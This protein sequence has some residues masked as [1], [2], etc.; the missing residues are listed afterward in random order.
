[1]CASASDSASDLEIVT[2][3]AL[4]HDIGKF[5]QRAKAPLATA[6]QNFDRSDY[7]EHGQ[8]A[9]YSAQFIDNEV[10]ARWKACGSPVLF[11]H[12]PKDPLAAIVAAADRFSAAEREAERPEK[13]STLQPLHSIFPSVFAQDGEKPPPAYF[14]LAR[15]NPSDAEAFFPSGS[16][17]GPDL[18]QKDYGRLWARFLQDHR[19]LV[20]PGFDAYLADLYRL[21]QNYTCYIPSAAYGSVPDISLFDHARTAAAIAGALYLYLADQGTLSDFKDPRAVASE[22]CFR[23]AEGDLSGIQTY[24]YDIANVGVGGVARRLRA[25]SLYLQLIVEV[26][27]QQL[28]QASGL[29][30]L[31]ALM[32]SGG[33]FYLLLPN[34]T[35]VREEIERAQD[36][37]DRWLRER[38][39]AELALN[40]ASVPLAG[41]E[42]GA[43]FGDVL[44]RAGAELA[45]RK[46]NRLGHALQ[47]DGRWQED[48]FLLADFGGRD[49]CRSCGQRPS[50]AGQEFCA[51]C[52][53]DLEVG[54]RL[55]TASALALYDDER[56]GLMPILGHSVELLA[57]DMLPERKAYLV[58]AF[59]DASPTPGTSSPT[60]AR[61]LC[62]YLP[63]WTEERRQALPLSEREEAWPGAPVTFE[64]LA[65][66][67]HGRPLL[68]FL[69]AD[70]DH[71]GETF[72][73]GLGKGRDTSSRLAQM[74]RLLDL[75]FSGWLPALLRQ[76]YPDIYS[77][78]AGGDD[79]LM[80]GP[81]DQALELASALREDFA[82]LVGNPRL[83]LSAGLF[84]AKPSYPIARAAYGADDLLD[85]AKEAGRNRLGL[86]GHTLTWEDWERL[87]ALWQKLRPEAEA[88]S[89]ALLYHFLQYARM[90]KS[91][92]LWE[93]DHN[94]GSVL[95][96]RLQPMLAYDISRNLN[97]RDFPGLYAFAHDLTAWPPSDQQRFILNYLDLLAQL[98]ITGRRGKN[99]P[100]SL[101][102]TAADSYYA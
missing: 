69:K 31:N 64:H 93:A 99:E 76:R 37:A 27:A 60:L 48:A 9:L 83:H 15:L 50:E 68:G 2:L 72:A 47:A 100:R 92:S 89:S 78:Y 85:K 66:R 74:S 22:P 57:A 65:E 6:W 86:L 53:M 94:Q 44:R 80:V 95:G 84:L 88:C 58:L 79:L 1:M 13:T 102:F 19:Q 12:N 62:N 43:A 26:A 55:P 3:A 39:G 18:Q 67:A 91:Y 82:R 40:L 71:L 17:P 38:L 20:P 81:W 54:R 14:G 56:T 61:W 41:S 45:Q 23:L 32:L 98:W 5:A 70:V 29:P 90:W 63:T 96:L 34:T 52:Q 36:R 35:A 24:L 49:P 16:A 4:L 28:L 101:E 25:R 33:R 11:H 30:F 7:G 59:A 87:R 21:L 97:E 73:F 10:D 46:A 75:F 77:V 42:L 51:Q 8:H